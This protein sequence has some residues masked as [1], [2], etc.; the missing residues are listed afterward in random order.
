MTKGDRSKIE[1][2]RL[3]YK[4]DRVKT[5]LVAEAPPNSLERFFYYENVK[6]KDYLF[7][8][9]AEALYP[10]LKNDFIE[11][12]RMP[13]KKSAIL[14]NLKKDGFYLIDL[15]DTP[16]S[17]L[18]DISV[19]SFVPDLIEKV[20]KIADTY[21]KIILI[22]ANVYDAAFKELDKLGF[23]VI[24]KRMPFPSSGQQKNFQ[25][26]FAEALTFTNRK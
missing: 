11:S 5:L 14:N 6:E 26:I 1:N 8:G 22:K 15:S 3:K 24:E 7:L 12:G 19:D 20:K 21:T 4:P 25:K 23:N 16:V 17:F 10:K 18:H 9:V 13:E 2:A